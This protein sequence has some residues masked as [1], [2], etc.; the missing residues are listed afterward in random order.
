MQIRVELLNLNYIY[1]YSY[2]S[3][4]AQ[5]IKVLAAKPDDLSSIPTPTWRKG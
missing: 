3:G 2:M 5:P 1:F 4:V